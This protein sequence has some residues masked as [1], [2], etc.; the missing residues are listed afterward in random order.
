MR[1]P[2]PQKKKVLLVGGTGAMGVYLAPELAALGYEVYITTRKERDSHDPSI[3]YITGNSKAGYFIKQVVQDG[4]DAIIDFMVYH[5]DEFDYIVDTFLE[6][7]QHYIFLSSYRVYGDN[8][9]DPIT[10]SSPRLLDSVDDE[11]YLATDEYGLTKARQ[12]DILRGK[13]NNHWSIIRPAITYSRDRFQLGTMEANEFLYRA[14]K[15]KPIVFAREMLDKKATMSWAGDVAKLI[16]KIVLNEKAYGEAYTASTSECHTW[17]E[18]VEMYEDLL[19]VK[20]KIIPLKTYIE[21]FGRQYQVKYD[22]MLHR[23]IDN[24]KIL[25]VTGMKQSDFMALKDGLRIELVEFSKNPHYGKIDSKREAKLDKITIGPITK[26][27]GKLWRKRKSIKLR[28]RI[29]QPAAFLSSRNY[30]GAIVTLTGYYNYGSM[31]Q[32]YAL[33]QFLLQHGRRYQLLDFDFMLTMS[34]KTGDRTQLER[35]AKEHFDQVAFDPLLSKYYKSY[36]V[37]SD[38]VWR[39]YFKNWSKF[40]RFFL[41][42]VKDNDA[43]RIAYA[44]SFGTESLAASGIT[45]AEQK[46]IRPLLKKFDAIS[47]REGSGVKLVR[48]LGQSADHVLDPTMLMTREFYSSVIDKS[49]Y[50]NAETGKLFYY[51]LDSSLIKLK[52][53]NQF[54]NDLQLKAE[55]IYPNNGEPLQPLEL[56]LKGFRDADFVVTDSF[57]GMVFSIINNTDFVVFGNKTRG[58]ARIAEL[59]SELGIEDRTI[60]DNVGYEPREFQPINWDEVNATLAKLREKSSNWLLDAVSIEKRTPIF[61]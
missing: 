54:E 45:G 53:I 11:V 38:Q 26:A 25:E 44:A 24:S 50:R 27:S 46:R 33:Q 5:T 36:I 43:V 34:K 19:H 52:A 22:R 49:E 56:W 1:G 60:E 58:L 16:A 61:E 28:T 59:L 30:D 7:T 23:Q 21:I 32:R 57:H 17:R 41:N 55:G 31:I 20:T 6:N 3:H 18:I 39:D 4:Y 37:G 2:A 48:W 29:K 9:S 35:F 51:I 10:E 12:E 42:F 15:G 13:A 14:L 8:G 47:V 40:G